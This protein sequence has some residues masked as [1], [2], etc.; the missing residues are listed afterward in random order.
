MNQ[1]EETL[2]N[3]RAAKEALAAK[4]QA[5]E[6]KLLSGGNIVDHTNEQQRA[7]DKRRHE[8]AE[9][10]RKEREMLQSLEKQE[11]SAVEIKETF[12]SLQQEVD[13]KTKKL[14]K[15]RFCP[16]FKKNMKLVKKRV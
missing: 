8:L 2:R 16:I 14:K 1:R 7:L 9:Q 15:V 11:E 5:M 6:G 3:E 10:K 12:N 13:V 4:I